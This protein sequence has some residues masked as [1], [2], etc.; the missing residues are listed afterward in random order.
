[1]K[2]GWH[3]GGVHRV[4]KEWVTGGTHGSSLVRET[5]VK[6]T[7]SCEPSPIKDDIDMIE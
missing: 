1:M 2:P 4:E 3:G 5:N 7:K 6:C